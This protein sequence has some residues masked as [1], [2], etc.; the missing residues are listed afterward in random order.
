MQRLAKQ[1]VEPAKI[2]FRRWENGAVIG[3]TDLTPE[4]TSHYEAPY[5]VVH[6]AHLHTALYEQ[7]AALG[8][9]TRLNSKVARYDAETA[10]INLTDGTVFQGDLVV[11]ADGQSPKTPGVLLVMWLIC[12]TRREIDSPEHCLP[13]RPRCSEVHGLCCLPRNSRGREDEGDP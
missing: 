5:Y 13:Q 8:V 6:R 9:K 4:F 12:R 11:A 3:V 1:V 10:T 2:N 7:A